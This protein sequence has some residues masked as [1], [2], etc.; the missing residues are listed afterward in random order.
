M[1]DLAVDD[2]LDLVGVLHFPPHP[3]VAIVAERTQVEHECPEAELELVIIQQD[4]EG[5]QR[6]AARRVGLRVS[7]RWA[8]VR[9]INWHAPMRLLLTHTLVRCHTS[10]GDPPVWYFRV[11]CAYLSAA[12]CIFFNDFSSFIKI[13]SNFLW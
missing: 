1:L 2:I 5:E 10:Q 11:Y 8:A 9:T 6:G 7:A 4:G 3:D 13:E 12:K